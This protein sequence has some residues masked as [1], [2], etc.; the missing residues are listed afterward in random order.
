MARAT[1]A[2]ALLLTILGELVLPHGGAVW[3]STIVGALGT[4]EVEERNARQ[5]LLRLAESGT[6]IRSAASAM[7][8]SAPRKLG[9]S[10]ETNRP[11]SVFA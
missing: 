6:I 2:K 10:T 4:L 5:A 8:L 9:T 11:D 7:A 3:T 1:S